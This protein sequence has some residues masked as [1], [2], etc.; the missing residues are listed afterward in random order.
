M[1]DEAIDF[2]DFSDIPEITDEQWSGA[3]RGVF[4]R[5]ETRHIS[6]RLSAANLLI[7][8]KPTTAK[9]L[10]YQTYIK[11]LLHESLLRESSK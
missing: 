8:N 3:V 11:R 6:I 10:P 2:I 5:P 9:G 7:A 4:A 1:R